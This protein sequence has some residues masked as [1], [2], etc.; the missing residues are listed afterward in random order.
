MCVIG[1]WGLIEVIKKVEKRTETALSQQQA[2][3]ITECHVVVANKN[4]EPAPNVAFALYTGGGTYVFSGLTDAQ[5]RLDS[6]PEMYDCNELKAIH[7]G[8]LQTNHAWENTVILLQQQA[9][10]VTVELLP[11]VSTGSCNVLMRSQESSELAPNI[12]FAL[13]DS[14]GSYVFS[15]WTDDEGRLGPFPTALNCDEL[16]AVYIGDLIINNGWATNND[17]KRWSVEPLPEVLR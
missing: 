8:S 6:F 1:A 3:G 2:E 15:G 16:Q 4:G 10:S 14:G 17:R 5:G 9:K 11:Q 13:Y 7:I 12:P